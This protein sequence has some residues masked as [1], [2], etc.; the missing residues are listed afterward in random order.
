[1]VFGIWKEAGTG[2][3]QEVWRSPR[4]ALGQ[5]PTSIER[6]LLAQSG[7]RADCPCR[8]STNTDIGIFHCFYPDSRRIL[9]STST[10][11]LGQFPDIPHLFE[12]IDEGNDP[13]GAGLANHR[14]GE[15]HEL[16]FDG[17]S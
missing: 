2:R 13:L 6:P 9:L 15:I 3:A 12:A 11:G 5:K 4:A 17:R 16:A 7:H 10:D 14:D 1:M 8:L